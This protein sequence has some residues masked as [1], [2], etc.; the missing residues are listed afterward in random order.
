MPRREVPYTYKLDL[1]FERL[2]TNEGVLLASTKRS[3]E[4][5]V[6][7]ISWGMVGIIWDRPVFVVLVR[8]SRYTY[9]F[10]EDSGVFTV[11]IPAPDM[12]DFVALCGTNSGREMDKL[13]VGAVR[14][15]EGHHVR[16]I[17]IG[18][19]P[20]VYECRVIHKNDVA[21]AE[22]PP[23]I[24]QGLYSTGNF[25]RLYYGEILGTYA[26]E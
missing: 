9:E 23:D 13:A 14:V 5:N 24:L 22:L 15:S 10:I 18:G 2:R 19:C 3:G 11:N 17:T 25:H 7:T 21:P 16:T 20:L 26:A 4:S 1:L 8:P 6:M 12:S